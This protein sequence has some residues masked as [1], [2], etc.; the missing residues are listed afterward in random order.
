MALRRA[1]ARAA[2]M[3]FVEEGKARMTRGRGSARLGSKRACLL[4]LHSLSDP[5]LA[6]ADAGDLMVNRRSRRST[7]G[8]RMDIALA[9]L[10]LETPDSAEDVE[11]DVDFV[12][13]GE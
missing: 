12:V 13:K 7:A 4:S 10:A 5:C 9:E 3:L 11:A 1:S 6:M 2:A 8:N